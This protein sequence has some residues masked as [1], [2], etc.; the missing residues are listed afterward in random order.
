MQFTGWTL[1]ICFYHTKLGKLTWT[2]HPRHVN[3]ILHLWCRAVSK[4]A[5]DIAGGRGVCQ[6]R[7]MSVLLQQKGCTWTCLGRVP[8][9]VVGKQRI[10]HF[11]KGLQPGPFTHW[12]L[13]IFGNGIY[14]RHVVFSF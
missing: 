1:P 6:L 13:V 11:E 9:P 4:R 3:A 12:A 10:T 14:P 7:I 5:C 2:L 8:L